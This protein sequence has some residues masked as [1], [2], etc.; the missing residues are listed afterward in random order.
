MPESLAIWRSG[1]MKFKKY[2][3]SD[4]A[5]HTFGDTA[6]VTG[7]LVRERNFMGKVRRR[8]R[9]LPSFPSFKN[10]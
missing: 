6:V 3:T 10:A 4:L 9:S 7:A 5:I 2:E 8:T 1:K